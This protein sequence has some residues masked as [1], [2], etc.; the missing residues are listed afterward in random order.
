MSRNPQMHCPECGKRAVHQIPDGPWVGENGAPLEWSHEDR[1]FL[2]LATKPN[3]FRA[4]AQPQAWTFG[5][6]SAALSRAVFGTVRREA[7]Q[8]RG[9][10]R[11]LAWNARRTHTPNGWAKRPWLNA[12]DHVVHPV[13]TA[14]LEVEQEMWDG[15]FGQ[16]Y[17][18]LEEMERA[19]SE[20]RTSLEEAA[21]ERAATTP[22]WL[23]YARDADREAGQ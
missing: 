23:A 12:W 19:E 14:R 11:E 7:V 4:P 18:K 3:G 2:C 21:A 20:R 1:S 17:W 22:D 16:A 9:A 15:P 13:R 10:V 5:R 8:L 6:R